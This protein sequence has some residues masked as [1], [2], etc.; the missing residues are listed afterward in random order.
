[1]L[2]TLQKTSFAEG[3]AQTVAWYRSNPDYWADIECALLPHPRE[4]RNAQI[5]HVLM[6]CNLS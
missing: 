3:F 1:M 6:G 2:L 5:R 4:A